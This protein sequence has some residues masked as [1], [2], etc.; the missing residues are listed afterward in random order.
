MSNFAALREQ[1]QQE[2]RE[3]E[4]QQQEVTIFYVQTTNGSAYPCPINKKEE[5]PCFEKHFAF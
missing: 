5:Q 4:K 2:Q 1:F 3:I